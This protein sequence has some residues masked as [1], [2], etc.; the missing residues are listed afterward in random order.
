MTRG[1]IVYDI[2]QEPDFFY[3]VRKGKLIM[4]TIIEID[5]YFKYPI[6]KQSWEVRKT[7]RQIRYKLQTLWKGTCFG[8]EEI[9]QGYQRRCQVRALT[10]CTLIH[11]RGSEIKRKWP[12]EQVEP[13]K[14]KM[15]ILD[16]DYIVNKIERYQ[17]EKKKRNT[18]V[19]DASKLN[20]HDFSGERSSFMQNVNKRQID[21]MIPWISKARANSTKNTNLLHELNKVAVLGSKE[22]KFVFRKGDDP[23]DIPSDEFLAKKHARFVVPAE[24]EKKWTLK[25]ALEKHKQA[26]KASV[27]S[28]EQ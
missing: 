19:L 13:L 21:K 11:V 3:V 15:R 1:S 6:D 17:K 25:D 27:T 5:S 26:R 7:S 2:D 9:L 12:A 4:E 22:E 8:H 14:L 20:C 18:A 24:A 16:L 10:D 28:A 23:D